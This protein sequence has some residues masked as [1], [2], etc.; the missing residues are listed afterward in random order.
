M[1]IRLRLTATEQGQTD[2]LRS[3]KSQRN[4]QQ[5]KKKA[6]YTGIDEEPAA[7]LTIIAML[8]GIKTL[9]FTPSDRERLQCA[10]SLEIEEFLPP[11]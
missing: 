5:R 1:S 6:N 9:M 2:K 4:E 11:L 7:T 10:E 3:I 8:A